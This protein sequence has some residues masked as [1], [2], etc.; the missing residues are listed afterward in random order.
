LPCPATEEVLLMYVTDMNNRGLSLSTIQVYL[1]AVRSLHIQEGLGDPLQ[2]C[3]R[4]RYALKAVKQGSSPARQKLP[5]THS[6]MQRIYAV[7][8]PTTDIDNIMLWSAFTLA[9]FGLF[10]A[11]EVTVTSQWCHSSHYLQ[12]EDVQIFS[13]H[14][15]TYMTVRLKRSKTDVENRGTTVYIGCSQTTVCAVCA[16]RLYLQVRVKNKPS[17]P[18][19]VFSSGQALTKQLFSKHLRLLLQQAGVDP[20]NYSG[21]SL[22]SGGATDAALSGLADWEIKLAGRWSSEAYQRYIRA[23]PSTLI[24]FAHRMIHNTAK[25]HSAFSNNI[26]H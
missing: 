19:F 5:V 13:D 6:I 14:V 9:Y 21:H 11:S 20:T 18:L 8:F 12:I 4:L 15:G 3:L 7:L 2:N 17:L 25:F 16:M 10:R 26:F 24:T 22:R 1:A 23:P